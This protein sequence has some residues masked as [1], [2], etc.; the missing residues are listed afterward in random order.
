MK[1][2]RLFRKFSRNDT[3]AVAVLVAKI[4]IILHL[5][6]VGVI[7]LYGV[8]LRT[9][10]PPVA[11]IMIYRTVFNQITPKKQFYIPA[12]NIKRKYLN[13]LVGTED[14]TFYHHN[15]IDIPSIINAAKVNIK[16]KQ[17]L[18]GASTITQQMTR[19]LIFCPDKMYVR[20]YLE[21]IAALVFDAVIPKERQLEL[22]VNYAEWGRGIYGIN[23]AAVRYYGKSVSRLDD[24]QVL[25]LITLLPSPVRYTPFTFERRPRL[26][27][28]YDKLYEIMNT[29]YSN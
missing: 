29:Y 23:S 16:Y 18:S 21:V 6:F 28:R 19:T 3:A 11:S 27:E 9:F 17:K 14:P 10:N 24:D 2:I 12:K 25:R 26:H 13:L 15:G 8:Y 4:I 5:A 7:F 22:Y 1:N 20:K